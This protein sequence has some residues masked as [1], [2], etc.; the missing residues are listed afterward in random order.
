[1][2]TYGRIDVLFNNAAKAYFNWVEDITGD[3]WHRNRRDDVDLVFYLTHAAWP[4]L[5]ASHGVVVNTASL[6]ASLSFK[7]LGSLARDSPCNTHGAPHS[8]RDDWA[9]VRRSP[10]QTTDRRTI[11]VPGHAAVPMRFRSDV[12][13]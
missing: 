12:E 5:K 2:K 13:T 8:C 11:V 7:N 3:E 9:D 4:H 6:N 10:T 1:V